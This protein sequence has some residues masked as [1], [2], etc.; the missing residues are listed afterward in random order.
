MKQSGIR[1]GRRRRSAR[2]RRKDFRDVAPPQSARESY[3]KPRQRPRI[4]PVFEA[5]GGV[6]GA[7]LLG[8]CFGEGGRFFS[9]QRHEEHEG[10]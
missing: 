6:E 2:K 3:C 8:L 7:V 1:L 10:F 5:E 4:F 9:P